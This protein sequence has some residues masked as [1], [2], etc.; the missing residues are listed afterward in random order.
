MSVCEHSIR[1]CDP[2]GGATHLDLLVLHLVLDGAE[3]NS[4]LG[5]IAHLEVLGE[6]NHG[7]EEFIVD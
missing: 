4:L 3:E 5:P 6:L 7:F 1:I 2:D